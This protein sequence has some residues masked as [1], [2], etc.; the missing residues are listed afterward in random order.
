MSLDA[1]L[2]IVQNKYPQ[3]SVIFP[4][5]FDGMDTTIQKLKSRSAT[6]FG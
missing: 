1:L 4:H 3:V 5:P 2:N 6:N